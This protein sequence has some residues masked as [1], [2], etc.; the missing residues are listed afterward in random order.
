[1]SSREL[2]WA[3][4]FIVPYWRR[5]TLVLL[6]SLASTGLSL[7]LPYLSKGLVDDAMIGRDTAV[8][9]RIVALL[10]AITLL[11]FGL[12]VVSGLRYTRVSAE[13][14]FDMRLALYR[15][16]QRLSPRFYAA[17]KL[18][19]IVSRI[20]NDIGEI[21]RVA[22]E[23]ALAWVG[24]VLFLIGTVVI[25]VG[26][27]WRLFLVSVAVMPFSLWALVR[28]RRGL[29]QR[30]KVM[31]ERSADIG[32]FLIETLQGMKLIV[33][34]N[35]Q[36]REIDRFR[37]KNDAFIRALMSMR[38]L[39]YLSGGLPGLILSVGTAVIFLYGGQRVISG[40]MTLGTLVAFMAYQMR[41]LSPVQGLMGL[42][43][44]LATARV[45]LHRVH[46]IL[47]TEIEVVEVADA[48]V[49][50]EV[51]GDVGFE[52][53]SFAFDRGP[54]LDG[55]SLSVGAGETLAIVGPSGAGKSTI[56]DLLLRHLD[57]DAGTVLLDGH[58]L[59]LL[60]LADL[61]RHVVPVE[62]EPF[63]FNASIAENIRYARPEAS[64][65]EVVAA[66]RSAGLDAFIEELPEG[67]ATEVG[68][69]GMAVSAGER[70][71]IAIAR[72]FLADPAVLLLDEA[73]ASLDPVAE[74]QVIE[75][76]E[77]IMRGRTT[78]LI[79]HR[80]EMARKADRV[81]VLDDAR[82]VEEGRPEE[83][84][85]ERGAF[86]RLFESG[87]ASG[88]PTVETEAVRHGAAAPRGSGQR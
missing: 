86:F 64:D 2:S 72:A 8:L 13:I 50:S 61:R 18:G 25:L 11:S 19:E 16:L 83:L 31:R 47:D 40:A 51:K 46:E 65:E 45:S 29:E 70:Q 28:Y 30:V 85:G 66:A 76:Y 42:Y 33:A 57:P 69:R 68:E 1:M 54:V 14:L 3:L 36:E 22:A 20:N 78:I 34:S 26:L 4:R 9:V 21:Q 48:L 23:A 32:N 55:V 67:F 17:T 87:A 79:S 74:R 10:A 81:A 38:R 88:A 12:N 27:D 71:R 49:L 60:R 62:Q 63:V 58:D 52:R 15:H 39:G 82:I 59:R 80:L 7:Y 84:W 35:A 56:V 73:T 37:G 53:V 75:G 5:L 44:S 41:L 77:A 24:N 43:T 6:V